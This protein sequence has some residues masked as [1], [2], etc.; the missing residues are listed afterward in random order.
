VIIL[1]ALIA[2]CLLLAFWACIAGPKKVKRLF[3]I[4]TFASLGPAALLLGAERPIDAVAVPELLSY[5]RSRTPRRMLGDILFP[6]KDI[7]GLDWKAVIGANRLPVAAK[8]VAFNQEASTASREG[9]EMQAGKI[10][11]IKRKITIDEE[12]MQKLYT[13]RPNTSE[14]DDAIAEIYNDTENMITAVETKI[15]AIRWEIISTGRLMLDEDGI[16]Q[17]VEFGFNPLTQSQTLV[18]NA[19]WSATATSTPIAD[20]IRWRNSIVNRTGVRP[21]RAVTSET[22]LAWIL[23]SAEVNTLV[24]GT[25]GAGLPVTEA[26]LQQLLQTQGLPPIVTYDDQYRVQNENG[27]YTQLRY[28]PEDLFVMMPGT[29]LGDQLYSPT[30]EA[31][32]KVRKGVINYG[33]AR[34][35]YAEVW[36][37]NEPPAHWTKAAALTFP[38]C[39]LIDSIFIADVW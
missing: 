29:K 12:T 31:L 5:I 34:R 3:K 9:I 25:L 37:E 15:E 30:V 11:P 24:H 10:V 20:M 17:Q 19:L 8:V 21:G 22:N 18:G 38:T 14:L 6:A 7:T 33:D 35:I 36:E 32:K 39:P 27:T 23:Q 1:L 26:Q 16:V 13:P 4:L 2:V 28:L